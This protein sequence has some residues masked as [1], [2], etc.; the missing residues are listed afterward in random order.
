MRRPSI[1]AL[2]RNAFRSCG[3]FRNWKDSHN[4]DGSLKHKTAYFNTSTECMNSISSYGRYSYTPREGRKKTIYFNIAGMCWNTQNING[5]YGSRF[6][7]GPLLDGG[8]PYC[9]I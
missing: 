8:A 7:I 2:N 1:G 5:N 9:A 3:K 4:D 6:G